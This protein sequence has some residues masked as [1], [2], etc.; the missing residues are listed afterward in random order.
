[1]GK[2]RSTT[3]L[4]AYLLSTHPS[5][6]PHSALQFIRQTRPLAEPN[7]GFKAQLQLYHS[8][9]CTTTLDANP[10]YNRWLYQRTLRAS[11]TA[12]T[13]P[14]IN[15]LRFSDENPT[16][17]PDEKE[18]SSNTNQNPTLHY[19]CRRCRTPLATSAYL[20]PHAAA[21]P[22]SHLHITPLSWMRPELELGKLEGRLECPNAKCGQS[23]GRYAWQGMK[24]SC[25]EWVVPG[26]TLGR[27]RVDEVGGGKV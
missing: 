21:S 10:A 15:H 2:S 27:G 5:L 12:G 16:I 8:T 24:C 18:T 26:M 6:T 17:P 22:C 9:A 4:A 19:R 7:L 14:E 25:G 23:V 11:N 1:M 20:V 13:A 3:L